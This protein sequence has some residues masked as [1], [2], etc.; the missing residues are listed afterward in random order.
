[1]RPMVTRLTAI[2]NP[3]AEQAFVLE[4]LGED[5]AE[6]GMYFIIDD[7]TQSIIYPAFLYLR[8]NYGSA[9]R[10]TADNP[11][12]SFS[13]N[14]KDAYNLREWLAFLTAIKRDW[15]KAD[16]ETLLAYAGYQISRVSQHSGKMRDPNTVG[17]K[18]GTV[19]AFYTYT[20]AIRLTN[21]SWD[22]KAVAARYQTNRRRRATEDENIRPF[23]KD[24]VPAIRASLGN[25]P[26]ELSKDSRRSTRDRLL[27]E[28][29]VRTGMRGE[30]I[31]FLR[32]SAFK[33]LIPDP[34]RPN[35][36]QPMRVQVTKGRI[37]RTVAVPNRLIGELKAYIDGERARSVKKL[38]DRGLADHG[39]LFVNFDDASR[40]GSKLTTNTLQRDFNAL[41]IKLDMFEEEARTKK[42][43]PVK[44]K[45][46]NHS[47]HDTR[48]TFAVRYYVGLKVQLARNPA[49]LNYAEPWELVQIALGHADWATTRKHYLRH[50]GEY[51]AAIGERVNEWLEEP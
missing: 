41:M 31:C 29:G 20:N 23:G 21:V 40:P 8:A 48:H 38:R 30:E 45:V 6:P 17:I 44:V 39:Y 49:A 13:T 2:E 4:E 11:V 12:P 25:L 14:K 24:D 51:E 5:R 18:L 26:S 7:A 27:F 43:V 9:G 34:E 10:V 32:A 36:T 28:T 47:F 37:H 3:T 1:M 15:R 19:K 33:R 22:A 16:H 46:P 35:A 50:V 42:G